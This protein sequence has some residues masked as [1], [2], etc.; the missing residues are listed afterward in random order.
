MSVKM[1]MI[2]S[3][4]YDDLIGSSKPFSLHDSRLGKLEALG[5]AYINYQSI[6]HTVLWYVEPRIIYPWIW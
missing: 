5:L 3:K 6:V 4:Y 1:F 2:L